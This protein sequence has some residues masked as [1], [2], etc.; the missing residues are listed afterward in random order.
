MSQDRGAGDGHDDR[1]TSE[2]VASLVATVQALVKKELELAKLEVQRIVVDKAVAVGA[3]LFG[4]LLCVF[5]LAFVG[6]TGAKALEEAFAPWIAWT[7]V[8]GIYLLVAL[9]V[10]LVAYRFARRPVVPERT[11]ASVEDTIGW[12]RQQVGNG[13]PQADTVATG[14]APD[15]SRAT[16]SGRART[17]GRS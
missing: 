12:A 11:K 6:V 10:L 1:A 8:T 2:V 9:I 14:A 13:S 4:A 3:A 17:G 16:R 15:G 5:V 7:I